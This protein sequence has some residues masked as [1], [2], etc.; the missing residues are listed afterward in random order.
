MKNCNQHQKINILKSLKTYYYH[1][2]KNL[3]KNLMNKKQLI[4]NYKIRIKVFK[5]N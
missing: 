4:V 1:K 2:K 5:I 3:K